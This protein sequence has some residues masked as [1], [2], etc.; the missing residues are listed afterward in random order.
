LECI[1]GVLVFD[2]WDFGVKTAAFAAFGDIAALLGAEVKAP[3]V[4]G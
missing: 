2:R 4:A 3:F 1:G